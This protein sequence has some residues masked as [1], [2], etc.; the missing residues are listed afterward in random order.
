MGDRIESRERKEPLDRGFVDA[1]ECLPSSQAARS[2]VAIN[3]LLSPDIFATPPNF[4]A[5][6][7]WDLKRVSTFAAAPR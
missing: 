5:C 3:G 1:H 2:A 7:S 6:C 4:Q